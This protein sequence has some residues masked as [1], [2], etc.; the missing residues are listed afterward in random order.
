MYERWQD[1]ISSH[2][3]YKSAYAIVDKRVF[4][5]GVVP[6]MASQCVQQCLGVCVAIDRHLAMEK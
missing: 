5:V 4:R 6:I 1:T 3:V 2:R